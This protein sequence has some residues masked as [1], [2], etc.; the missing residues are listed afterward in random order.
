[1]ALNPSDNNAQVPVGPAYTT[2][3]TANEL[4]VRARVSGDTY[5][6]FQITC[7]GVIKT[8]AGSGAPTPVVTFNVGSV[9]SAYTQTYS[10]AAKTVPAATQVAVVE[11]AAGLTAY[12]YTEA[13][14]NAIPVA[15]NA[16]AAD[17]LAL[18]KVV[19]AL[20][21]DLQAAGIVL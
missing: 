5:D 13:Q 3:D 14:A 7:G 10:T 1:M 19:N 6:R 15:I 18:K 17:I 9:G 2:A 4:L 8:G 16:A 11:T 20:I 21:D 12:G